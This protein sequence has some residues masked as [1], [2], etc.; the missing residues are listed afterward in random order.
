MLRDRPMTALNNPCLLTPTDRDN[1]AT[2]HKPCLT[3][4]RVGRWHAPSPQAASPS[5][6]THAFSPL[7]PQ[8]RL[9]RGH[10]RFSCSLYLGGSQGGWPLR[11][12]PSP[13]YQPALTAPRRLT[14][15]HSDAHA[16][17]GAVWRPTAHPT[18]MSDPCQHP[19]QTDR[20]GQPPIGVSSCPVG[21]IGGRVGACGVVSLL[22]AWWVLD[23]ALALSARLTAS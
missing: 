15:L 10:L 5:R 19:T 2:S 21:E 7:V 16:R 23:G 12:A 9:T 3:S 11:S 18:D 4:A 1:S 13:P 22:V 17:R 20:H 14:R 6:Q 8:P